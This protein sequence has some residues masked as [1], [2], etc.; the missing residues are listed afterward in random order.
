MRRLA[1]AVGFALLACVAAGCAKTVAPPAAVVGNQAP[2]ALRNLQVANVD[3]HRAVLL[4]LSRPPELVRQSSGKHPGRI[5]LQ[6]MGPAG[7]GDLSE[8][9]LAQ[10]D[11]LLNNVRVSRRQGAL[12]VVLEFKTE[13]PPPYSIHEM[14]DWIMVRLD[15]R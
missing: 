12:E 8:R 4:R 13:E 10:V 14:G 6:A 11:P 3:G 9:D 5:V 15:T 7:E 1:P 2:V